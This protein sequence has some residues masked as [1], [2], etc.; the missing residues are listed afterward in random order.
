[1]RAVALS[2]VTQVGARVLHLILNVVSSLAI[3]RYLAPGAYGVYAVVL[4]VTTLVAIAADF[5][6]PKLAIREICAAR[7]DGDVENRVL[8]TIVLLRLLLAFAGV[9]VAQVALLVLDQP[10]AAY[11]AAL[12]ASVTTIGEAVVA[13]V[14]VVF[15]V[16]VAQHYEALVRTGAELLETAAIL[17]L[18]SYQA[19][20]VWLFVPPAA[21]AALSA[22]CVILLARYRFG[23][24]LRLDGRLARRLLIA[25]LPIA[26][27]LLVGM[28]YRKVDALALAA[29]RP[30]HD[31]GIYGSAMQPVDYAF[32]S[33]ALLMN[34]V[35]PLM[36]AAH[37]R[38]DEERFRSLYRRGFEALALLTVA[39]PVLLLF[40]ARP[41]AVQVFGPA[42]ADAA[43]P[44]V[45]LSA[46][47]VPLALTVWQSLAL[48]LGGHQKA[49]LYYS[50]AALVVAAV[51]SVVLVA[52]FGT[53]GAGM[54]ALGTALFVLAA[55]SRALRRLMGVRL[56]AGPLLRIGVA[57]VMTVGA[58]GALSSIGVHSLV[59]GA[60][61][62][63]F[64]AAAARATGAHRSLVGVVT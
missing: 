52:A 28:L 51:L 49:T 12:V 17:V 27:T 50:A 22:A 13:A 54:A 45:L 25:A 4:T 3:V 36:A 40:V 20:L 43:V 21:G 18:I 29:L 47:M 10:A 8:G 6:L 24:R 38:G 16:R 56:E 33:T 26:P 63:L 5:G 44:L 15:H 37:G 2:A 31:V 46:A 14:V 1:M 57:V 7:D 62:L 64:F 11:P 58:L 9:A 30:S 60:A 59:L 55:S 23:R 32:L 39:L 19:S 41:L 42:Y 53:V 48:L 35:F 61:G 34:V